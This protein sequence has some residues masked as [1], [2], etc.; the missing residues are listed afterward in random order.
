MSVTRPNG[1]VSMGCL[2]PIATSD[3][4]GNPISVP[5]RQCAWCRMHQADRNSTLSSL[6]MLGDDVYTLFVTLTY[7]NEFI[8]KVSFRFNGL[9]T[10]YV[11]SDGEITQTLYSSEKSV[12][13]DQEFLKK[14]SANYAHRFPQSFRFGEIP[15]CEVSHIQSFLKRVHSRVYRKFKCNKMFRYAYCAEYGESS[16]RPHYHIL[17]FCKSEQ[18]RRFITSCICETWNYGFTHSVYWNGTSAD[19]LSRYCVGLSSVAKVYYKGLYRSRFRH[20]SCLGFKTIERLKEV[21]DLRDGRYCQF[22]CTKNNSNIVL[23][24]PHNYLHTI[25]PKPRDYGYLSPSI[26][27]KRCCFALDYASKNFRKNDVV[28]AIIAD[29][30][31]YE[32]FKDFSLCPHLSNYLTAFDCLSSDSQLLKFLSHCLTSDRVFNHVRYDVDISFN[33]VNAA[34]NFS[35]SD[36]SLHFSKL[37][38]FYSQRDEAIKEKEK[39]DYEYLK[40]KNP[41]DY[42]LTYFEF[43]HVPFS[44]IM[45]FRNSDNFRAWVA[46]N[47]ARVVD[48][49]KVKKQKEKYT[50][51]PYSTLTSY[52]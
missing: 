9:S 1:L 49:S 6:E 34:K 27:F 20:S 31:H 47:H 22:T 4:H 11:S 2:H 50:L 37:C 30:Q 17:L 18:V 19:Y 21:N 42:A 26:L 7:A 38:S 23:A 33:F 3:S 51:K 32:I 46:Y 40:Q 29:V 12:L 13:K 8:P 44:K 35:N 28:R 43:N 48:A 16:F 36:L 52:V 14:L 10:D 39:L 41:D 5:C 15:V 24:A 45:D 25:Y